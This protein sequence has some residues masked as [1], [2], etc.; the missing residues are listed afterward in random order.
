MMFHPRLVCS[1]ISFRHLS[2]PAALS[3]MR[4]LGFSTLDLGALPG[5]C[6]HVPFVLDSQAVEDVSSAIRSS[7][8]SVRSINADIGDL[9]VVPDSAGSARRDEHLDMLLGLAVNVDATAVVLPCGAQSRDPVATLNRD[10]ERVANALEDASQRAA[11]VG[12]DIWVESP[13]FYRLCWDLDRT[14]DLL[15]HL[16]ETVGLVM[17]FSH[18]EAS[19]ADAV[20]YVDIF[21]HRIRHVHLRDAVPGDINRSIGNGTVD[22]AAG[23]KALAASGYDGH[24][25]LELETRDVTDDERSQ[26]TLAAATY[27]SELLGSPAA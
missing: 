7:G 27:I 14:V 21:R 19:G 9:N 17:D 20:E 5:V 22:F 13:H 1:S 12:V 25:S 2:L 11:A 24:F 8:M 6:D 18:L 4:T 23:L 3:T 16:P 10:M 26:A 15:A